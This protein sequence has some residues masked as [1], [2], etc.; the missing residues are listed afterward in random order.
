MNNSINIVVQSNILVINIDESC[1]K[2]INFI[3]IETKNYYNKEYHRTSYAIP[4]VVIEAINLIVFI[5]VTN[6]I[7]FTYRYSYITYI[8][9]ILHLYNYFYK[10]IESF[11]FERIYQMLAITSK[12]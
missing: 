10:K 9:V 4:V 8:T 3:Q 7:V 12:T 6:G 1:N 11:F 5:N 2:L